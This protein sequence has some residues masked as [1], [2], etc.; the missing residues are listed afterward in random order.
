MYSVGSYQGSSEYSTMY[1]VLLR[2]ARFWDFLFQVDEQLADA[3][4]K[5]GCPCGGRLH[6]ANYPRKP[7]G[8]CEQLPG[9]TATA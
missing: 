3:A 6:R 8:G 1:H 9:F 2:D 7:R 5:A 4:C